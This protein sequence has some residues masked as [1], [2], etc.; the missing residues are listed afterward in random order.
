MTRR[1]IT[2]I[3][4]L[5]VIVLLA[6][7]APV[8][9]HLLTTASASHLDATRT[10]QRTT[11]A[12]YAVRSA[13]ARLRAA[14]ADPG[15]TFAKADADTVALS[16][17]TTVA[18]QGSDL[19]VATATT[20][21]GTLVDGVESF[22][23]TYE[24][25]AGVAFNPAS[26]GSDEGDIARITLTLTV[27]GIE[28][29][30]TVYRENTR[31]YTPTSS[32]EG[33]WS[34][35]FDG[36]SNGAT[37]DDGDTAWSTQLDGHSVAIHGVNNGRYDFSYMRPTGR[38]VVW[39]SE[40]ID[41]SALPEFEVRAGFDGTGSLDT[42]GSYADWIRVSLLL[43]GTEHAA[44]S[45]YGAQPVGVDLVSGPYS[46]SQAQI[47][48]S[49]YVS[50]HDEHYYVDDIAIAPARATV[51]S[52][53]FDGFA[54]G[55][56]EDTGE[57]AWS[58]DTSNAAASPRAV[59]G[60]FSGELRLSAGGAGNSGYTQYIEWRTEP[61]DVSEEDGVVV[62]V[63]VRSTTNNDL[64]ESGQWHDWFEV[65]YSVDGGPEIRVV[66]DDGDISPNPR[67]ITSNEIEDDELVI[68]IRAKTTGDVE[69]YL[70]DSVVVEA[71]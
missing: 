30:E 63:N 32:H 12:S 45:G 16:D 35:G 36:L 9:G 37:F 41:V 49:S 25:G 42:S 61:I 22:T 71:L 7:I 39:M 50:G 10:R 33:A 57:T 17:G 43:D 48:I 21:V 67:T 24:D 64:E 69:S 52:E 19:Q 23:I 53:S 6:A 4:T 56:D 47:L 28:L 14:L 26:D 27:D 34:E 55:E 18:M 20:P 13:A 15:V 2:L 51:W 29:T 65:L 38:E 60:V 5:A 8:L 31:E 58:I 1:A 11:D 3:E 62:E 59:A 54:D 46:G 70:I 40:Q 66:R 44:Y 68:I